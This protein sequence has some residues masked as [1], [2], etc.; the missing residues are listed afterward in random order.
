MAYVIRRPNGSWELRRSKATEA[1]PRSETLLTFREVTEEGILHAVQR[2]D[3]GL[4]AEQVKSAARRAGAP[5]ALAPARRSAL[6]LLREL[7][8]GASLPESWRAALRGVLANVEQD[9]GAAD[10]IAAWAGASAEQRGDALRDLLLLADAIPARQ[11]RGDSPKFPGFQT[12]IG[13]T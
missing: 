10:A 7:R 9:D 12:S 11:G 13:E 4:T 1:G 5:I 2:A 6:E 8:A 3:G